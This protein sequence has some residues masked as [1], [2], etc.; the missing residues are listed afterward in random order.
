MISRTPISGL[1]VPE[2]GAEAQAVRQ[3]T[4]MI[5]SNCSP[6]VF[7]LRRA[8]RNRASALPPLGIVGPMG[9]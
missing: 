6:E 5:R 1:P 8:Y 2:P 7:D 4:A 9:D 3:S